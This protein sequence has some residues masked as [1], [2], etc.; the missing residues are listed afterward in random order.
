MKKLLITATLMFAVSAFSEGGNVGS[1]GKETFQLLKWCGEA[2]GDLRNTKRQED[3][4]MAYASN[5]EVTAANLERGL[6]DAKDKMKDMT[7]E[8]SLVKRSIERGITIVT[9]M[10]RYSSINTPTLVD[11]LRDYY[12]LILDGVAGLDSVVS[13]DKTHIE[14]SNYT[15]R[16]RE[17]EKKRVCEIPQGLGKDRKFV[18]CPESRVREWEKRYT[19]YVSMQIEWLLNTRT[20]IGFFPGVNEKSD[21]RHITNGPVKGY[22]VPAELMT[23]FLASD[24][25]DS[26]WD[27]MYE[28]TIGEL[29]YLGK[30]LLNYNSGG[31]SI[32]PEPSFVTSTHNT[33]KQIQSSVSR[34]CPGFDTPGIPR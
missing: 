5:P 3:K 12:S 29:G 17:N 15:R 28:C 26:L 19:E 16:G 25:R 9:A 21:T 6:W 18:P 8:F 14:W 7:S 30:D 31:D 24:L 1:S 2:V 4:R 23:G 22:T 27:D 13:M 33:F 11:F 34:R 10:K 20:G 32:E